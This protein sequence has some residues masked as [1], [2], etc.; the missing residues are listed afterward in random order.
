MK[1]LGGMLSAA[2]GAA[3][4]QPAILVSIGFSEPVRW[5]S[6]STLS[7]G[8][9]TWN[10]YDVRLDGLNVDA[11]RLSG[12]LAIGNGDDVAAAM[13]LNEGIQ[14]RSISIWGYDAAAP[15]DMVWLADAAGGSAQVGAQQVLIELRHPCA[16]LLSPRTFVN[17]TSFGPTLP[18]G[19][20]L[21]I[22]G[23][24]VRLARRGG[25]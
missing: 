5:S 18:D 19:A 3:V 2:L 11:Y 25:G 17:A 4:Q 1:T 8:G 14:D 13:V 23:Q 9:Y 6:Y 10:K 16:L 22:N 12:T 21:R 7:W 24:D 15:T 20:V